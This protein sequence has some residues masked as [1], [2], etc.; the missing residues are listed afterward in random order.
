MAAYATTTK[1]GAARA[2]SRVLLG[3][4]GSG[5]PDGGGGGGTDE[6]TAAHAP[7]LRLLTSV[8]FRPEFTAD[9]EDGLRTAYARLRLL[10]DTIG[11]PLALAADP[12]AMARMHE[13][14][15]FV[16]PTLASVSTIHYNLFLGSLLDQGARTPEEW[17]PYLTLKEVGTFLMTE[18]AH[19]NDAAAVETT[20]DHDPETGGFTLHTPSAG[21]QKFMPNTSPVGGPKT[22]VVAA[23]LRVAGVDH[24]VSLFLTPLTDADGPLPGVR[25]RRLPPRLGSP[26][27]HCLTSFD[28]VRLPRR[29]LLAG[30]HSDLTDDGVF[31]S[32]VKDQRRRFLTTLQRVMTGKLCMSAVTVGSCRALLTLA[33]RYAAHRR[34]SGLVTG[35]T[36]P[37]G[38]LRSHHGPL[39]ESL[40]TT[41]AMTMLYR[42]AVRRWAPVEEGGG[43]ADGPGGAGERAESARLVSVAKAWI[44]WQGRAVAMEVRERCGAQGLLAHNGITGQL[45]AVEGAITAEGD[46]Q[47]VMVKAASELLYARRRPNPPGHPCPPPPREAPAPGA[48]EGGGE[49]EHGA[50]ER[51]GPEGGGPEGGAGEL[52]DPAFLHQLLA[53]AENI[54][55]DRARAAMRE[56]PH[57]ALARRNAAMGPALRAVHLYAH[58]HAARALAEPA[59]APTPAREPLRAVHLLFTLRAVAEHSGDLLRHGHLAERHVDELPV[60]TERFTTRVA[61]AAP[62]LIEAFAVPEEMFAGVPLA[63]PDYIADYDD[64]GG[65]WNTE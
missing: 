30:A 17:E 5:G 16:D 3:G 26:L 40:A 15:G 54:W 1:S 19:G 53:H 32:S 45:A 64:P 56:A 29:A 27:D 33:F 21:A 42:E 20:A 61:Q 50:H 14:L 38:A 48:H 63:S 57:E 8:P 49:P 44:T 6:P 43:A 31:T 18:V 65:P 34:V 11:D 23:R 36:L 55:L 52:T 22:G 41:Y 9:P 2:L 39:A 60:L 62:E 51:G 58:R 10:N 24:G 12:V 4:Y 37:V 25:V 46:N 47:A 28:R 59:A 13:W 35:T 7:W